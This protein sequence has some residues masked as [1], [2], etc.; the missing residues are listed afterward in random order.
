MLTTL[1]RKTHHILESHLGNN[2]DNTFSLGHIALP[3]PGGS[4]KDLSSQVPDSSRETWRQGC[5][6]S[7][8]A[9]PLALD[10]H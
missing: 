6:L 4:F 7:D 1:E 3:A 10:C 2:I 5:Q 8:A 9:D